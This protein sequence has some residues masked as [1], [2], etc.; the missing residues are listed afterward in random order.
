MLGQ[1]ALACRD[2]ERIRFGY[3]DSG[4]AESNRV[5]E[6][7]SVVVAQRAWFLV[8]WDVDRN[9]WRTF[10]V[11]RMATMVKTGL[12][13]DRRELP[14]D[15]ATAFVAASLRS[16]RHRHTAEVIMALPLAELRR[17]FG[18]WAREA[19]ALDSTHT[20]WP[21]SGDSLETLVTSL[22]WVP[23]GVAYELRGSPEVMQHLRELSDRLAAAVTQRPS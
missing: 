7:H 15:S 3:V 2:R 10:R 23:T 18:P 17:L 22:A 13:F 6:P 9:D 14:T 20:C 11:D 5:A 21:I 4:G 12:R 8:C 19:T 16:V 1:L